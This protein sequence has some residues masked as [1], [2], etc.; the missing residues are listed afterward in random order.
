MPD[1]VRV[2]ACLCCARVTPQINKFLRYPGRPVIL[3]MA[4]PDAKKNLIGLLKAY[5]DSRLLRDL[6]NLV[7]VMVRSWYWRVRVRLMFYLWP[8]H[9][10]QEAK[11]CPMFD[12]LLRP[13]TIGLATPVRLQM[14]R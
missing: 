1:A 3:A 11:L 12:T 8:S 5:G 13:G 14:N 2:C 6:A 10:S 9:L 4:R 7:L